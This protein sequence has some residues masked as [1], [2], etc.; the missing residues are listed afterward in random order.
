VADGVVDFGVVGV[1][2][3]AS[4]ML[5]VGNAG[6]TALWGEDGI[7]VLR[8]ALDAPPPFA[9]ESGPHED[10]AGGSLNAHQVTLDT[11]EPGVHEAVLLVASNDPERPVLEVV[12]RGEVREACAG[13][14][15]GNGVGN[16]LDVLAFLNDWS[17]GDGRADL[18]D[19]GGVDTLDFLLFLN[20][21]A[22]C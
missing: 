8:Y 3:P 12:L 21:W 11:S 22:A 15:D 13:D 2:E 7:G 20:L 18:N 19:D 10:G 9:V 17:A 16:T 5:A 14:W 4:A 1:G 6:D